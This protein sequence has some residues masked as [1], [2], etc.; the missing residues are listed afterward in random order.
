[1]KILP[2][3]MKEFRKCALKYCTLLTIS[4]Y[5]FEIQKVYSNYW[6]AHVSVLV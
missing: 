2:M 5:S 6:R 4:G 3:K 1:M